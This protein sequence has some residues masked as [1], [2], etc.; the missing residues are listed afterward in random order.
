MTLVKFA[1]SKSFSLM[2]GFLN[3]LPKSFREDFTGNGNVLIPVN[4]SE[5]KDAYQLEVAAPGM[6]KNNF[7]VNVEKNI[8]TVSGEKKEQVK[9][10]NE[11]QIRREFSYRSFKR[12]FTLDETIDAEKIEA[13]YLNGVLTL[14][15]PKKEVVKTSKEIA[16][17]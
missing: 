11:K 13:K 1:P 14:N 3:D 9:D 17:K 16:I 6:D 5:T 7:N 15:L 8:L 12:S 4:I 10:E 2:E